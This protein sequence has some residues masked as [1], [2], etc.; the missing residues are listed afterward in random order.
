[1]LGA[2]CRKGAHTSMLARSSSSSLLF[3]SLIICIICRVASDTWPVVM[4]MHTKLILSPKLS[5][6]VGWCGDQT[7]ANIAA[8]DM[9]DGMRQEKYAQVPSAVAFS[10]GY[11]ECVKPSGPP[12]FMPSQPSSCP[13]QCTKACCRN[14]SAGSMV[15]KPAM[16]QAPLQLHAELLLKGL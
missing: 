3:P 14:R 8:S 10:A 16:L 11:S 12:A 9:R 6:C 7:Q 15:H 4:R 5:L 13:S 1:M 2:A